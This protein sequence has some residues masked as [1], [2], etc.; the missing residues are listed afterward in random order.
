M[1]NDP[2]KTQLTLVYDCDLNQ[3]LENIKRTLPTLN[4]T[5]PEISVVPSDYG[6]RVDIQEDKEHA[7]EQRRMSA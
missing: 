2:N 5:K 7:V 4:F 1:K 6:W 3:V